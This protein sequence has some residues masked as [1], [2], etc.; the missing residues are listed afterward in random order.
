M[1][2][3]L[4]SAVNNDCGSLQISSWLESEDLRNRQQKHTAKP[5]VILKTRFEPI[6]QD[7]Q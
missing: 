6:K 4:V 1:F 5:L 3:C 7:I 2:Y